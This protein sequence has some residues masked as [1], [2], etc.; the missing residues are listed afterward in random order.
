MRPADIDA[1]NVQTYYTCYSEIGSEPEK[2]D[3]QTRETADHSMP[4]LLALGLVDGFVKA[5][6]FSP[7]KLRDTNC[8]PV[9]PVP[10]ITSTALVTCPR[11][12]FL[13]VPSVR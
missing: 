1:I 4:Y 6:S 11:A 10:C 13:M 9:P 2:W 12:S 3:P 7:E 8:A 5:D